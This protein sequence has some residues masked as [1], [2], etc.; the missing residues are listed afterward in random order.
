MALTIVGILVLLADDGFSG[1]TEL[2]KCPVLYMTLFLQL[3]LLNLKN[4]ITQ[5]ISKICISKLNRDQVELNEWY[6]EVEDRLAFEQ[7][8]DA[9]QF[10]S[11]SQHPYLF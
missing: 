4:T 10:F 5:V 7:Y 3:L 6:I 8:E 11:I 2:I 9:N 1:L